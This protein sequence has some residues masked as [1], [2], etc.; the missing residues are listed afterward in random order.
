MTISLKHTDQRLKL[1]AY[2]RNNPRV[3]M[4]AITEKTGPVDITATPAKKIIEEK[5]NEQDVVDLVGRFDFLSSQPS[6]TI[7]PI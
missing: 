3:V 5:L 2:F 1:F 4:E 7:M 6:S